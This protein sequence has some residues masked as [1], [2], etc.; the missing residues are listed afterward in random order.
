[1]EAGRAG[2]KTAGGGTAARATRGTPITGERGADQAPILYSRSP[3]TSLTPP[4]PP[5]SR[6]TSSRGWCSTSSTARET[7]RKAWRSHSLPPGPPTLTSWMSSVPDASTSRRSSPTPKPS[8]F[9]PR[10]PPFFASRPEARPVL[11]RVRSAPHLPQRVHLLTHLRPIRLLLP[12]KE[13]ED[14]A[15]FSTR[16]FFRPS[17][18]HPRPLHPLLPPSLLLSTPFLSDHPTD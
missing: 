8:S 7:R 17:R 2:W 6:P 4:R 5:R 1:M 12:Q 3:S 15:T 13:L 16:P 11:P 10:A 14:D 18:Q 9:A